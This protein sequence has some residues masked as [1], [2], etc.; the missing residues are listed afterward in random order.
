[1]AFDRFIEFSFTSFYDCFELF[2][3]FIVSHIHC[4]KEKN[5]KE[6]TH[7]PLS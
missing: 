5:I 6:G 7:P 3:Y 1:M 2:S 4:K